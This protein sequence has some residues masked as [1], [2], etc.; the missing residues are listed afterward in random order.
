MNLLDFK[1]C[2]RCNNG[3]TVTKCETCEFTGFVLLDGSPASVLLGKKEK[4]IKY[5]ERKKNK[6]TKGR[7]HGR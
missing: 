7:P 5:Q 3:T 2:P 6:Q 1:R 4:W